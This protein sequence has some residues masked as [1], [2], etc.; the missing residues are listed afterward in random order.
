MVANRVFQAPFTIRKEHWRA[1]PFDNQ[2]GEI[3]TADHGLTYEEY[4]RTKVVL[5][6]EEI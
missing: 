4:D 1:D 3:E 5:S 6:C 2:V